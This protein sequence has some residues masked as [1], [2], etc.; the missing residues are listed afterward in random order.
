MAIVRR[1]FPFACALVLACA[2]VLGVGAPAASAKTPCW[3]V[4]IN[5]WYDG[6]IDR[7]YPAA[8]YREAQKHVPQDAAA[9]S[10][11]PEDLDRALQAAIIKGPVDPGTPIA[12]GGTGRHPET[13]SSDEEAA[14]QALAGGDDKGLLDKLRPANADSVPIPLL[15]LAGLAVLLLAAAAASYGARWFQARRTALPAGPNGRRIRR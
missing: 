6:R 8:C 4:L 1:T 3:R 5:D 2:A 7:T 14:Q 10:S 15:I 9:Y 11:L 13:P 12:A